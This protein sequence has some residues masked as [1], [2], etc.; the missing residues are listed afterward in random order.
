MQTDDWEVIGQPECPILLRRT[1]VANRFGKILLHYFL[2][3]SRDRDPHDHPASFVTIVLRGGYDDIQPCSF[4]S[5]EAPGWVLGEESNDWRHARPM[6]PCEECGATGRGAVDEV[7][8]PAIRF[9]SAEHTHT[10]I[11]GPEGAWTL[12]LMGPKR[13]PWGFLRDGRWWLWRQY[14]ERFGH[15]FRCPDD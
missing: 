3:T 5:A 2:P 14:E 13:K 8:A 10:T 9:R 12:V 11:A 6:A 4:C 7:R 15:G 1:L